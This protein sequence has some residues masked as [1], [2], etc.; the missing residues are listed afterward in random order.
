MHMAADGPVSLFDAF[1]APIERPNAA[2]LSEMATTWAQVL[3]ARSVHLSKVYLTKCRLDHVALERN[4]W[5]LAQALYS[6]VGYCKAA[7]TRSACGRTRIS[8]R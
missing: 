4:T 2:A 3:D 6:C 8:R 5:L 7:L 1:A